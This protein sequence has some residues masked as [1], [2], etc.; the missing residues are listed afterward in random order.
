MAL[1]NGISTGTVTFGQAVSIVGGHPTS[2]TFTVKPTHNLVHQESGIQLLDFSETVR[3]EAGMPGSIELPFTDQAGFVDAAGAPFK[4][5]AYRAEGTW[6][7]GAETR[8]FEKNFQLVEGQD[9]VDFDLIPNGSITLPVTAPVATVTAVLGKTGNI[10]AAD[11]TD[12]GI[13]GGEP[14]DDAIAPLIASGSETR[15][16]VEAVVQEVGSD[17]YAPQTVVQ[18]VDT[19]IVDP[20]KLAHVIY[21]RAAGEYRRDQSTV[22]ASSLCTHNTAT[23]QYV[24]VGPA[25]APAWGAL[26][27][28]VTGLAGGP[29]VFAAGWEQ[30]N[31][32]VAKTITYVSNIAFSYT[33]ALPAA[34]RAGVRGPAIAASNSQPYTVSLLYR[35]NGTD[36]DKLRFEVKW[37]SDTNG[38]GATL[39]APSVGG[40]RIAVTLAPSTIANDRLVF[41]VYN[42]TGATVTHEVFQSDMMCSPRISDEWRDVPPFLTAARAALA[43]TLLVAD[44]TYAVWAWTDKGIVSARV[45]ASAG[46]G[47]DLATTFGSCKIYRLAAWRNSVYVDGMMDRVVAPEYR[48]VL[49]TDHLLLQRYSPKVSTFSNIEYHGANNSWNQAKAVN[50]AHRDKTEVRSGDFVQGEAMYKRRAELTNQVSWPYD[51]DVW[52]SFHFRITGTLKNPGAWGMLW[53][54]RYTDDAGDTISLAPELSVQIGQ[55]NALF[56]P[57]SSTSDPNPSTPPSVVTRW[58]GTYVPGKWHHI[59]LRSQFSKTGGG[60][61]GVWL[62][63]VNVFPY[64]AVPLGYNKTRGPRPH[65]GFYGYQSDERMVIEHANVEWGTNDLGGRATLPR[66]V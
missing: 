3:V 65:W 24:E 57:T 55:N 43:A 46:G 49:A 11:F 26:S 35:L 63:G 8:K 54:W 25:V 4:N 16:A 33:Q 53:Q 58:S 37:N 10:T 38:T 32:G 41:L 61:L 5:W 14:T 62:D 18:K 17:L 13:G 7:K 9:T 51:T 64:A 30:A 50:Y 1:P 27:G 28:G 36:A 15:Q 6:Q 59:L 29:G 44:G 56:V 20:M 2:M 19:L 52:T 48:P 42:P 31:S 47:I 40:E 60:N 66:P 22:S 21:D 45:T 39:I 23:D 34:G 12:A